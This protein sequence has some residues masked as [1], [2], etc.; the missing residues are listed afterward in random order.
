MKGLG[1][2]KAS[3]TRDHLFDR[4]DMIFERKRIFAGAICTAF[5]HVS[6]QCGSWETAQRRVG[7]YIYGTNPPPLL[8]VGSILRAFHRGSGCK[9]EPML[10]SIS[11]FRSGKTEP[12]ETS[13][14]TART[15]A[16]KDQT[17]S[18]SRTAVSKA[19]EGIAVRRNLV[20]GSKRES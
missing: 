7:A 11:T 17:H 20:R 4:L 16:G 13:F 19:F 2:C 3:G 1:R 18:N 8:H 6:L 12:H 10:I 14:E 5:F 9:G 15:F